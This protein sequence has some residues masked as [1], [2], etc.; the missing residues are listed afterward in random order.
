MNRVMPDAWEYIWLAS[1]VSRSTK[2][3][4]HLLRQRY[5]LYMNLLIECWLGKSQV[6]VSRGVYEKLVVL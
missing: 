1:M 3:L 2:L 4:M 5:A 6:G